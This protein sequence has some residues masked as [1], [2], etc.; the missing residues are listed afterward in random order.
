MNTIDSQILMADVA[1]PLGAADVVLPAGLAHLGPAHLAEGAAVHD[2]PQLGAAPRAR[3][4]RV[5]R[6]HH[7]AA[8][9]PVDGAGVGVRLRGGQQADLGAAPLQLLEFSAQSTEKER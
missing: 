7:G 6:P 2:A 9:G 3:P 8:G 4:A 5:G 1:D